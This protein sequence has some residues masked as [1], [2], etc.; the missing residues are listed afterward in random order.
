MGEVT[1]G[2]V[3][4]AVMEALAVPRYVAAESDR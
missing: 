3:V 4:I 1:V 2:A